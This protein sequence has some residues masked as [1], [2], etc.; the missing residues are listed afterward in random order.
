MSTEWEMLSNHLIRCPLL[1]LP[2]IFPGF[3][4]FS[5]HLTLCIKW[6]KCWSF[7]FSISPSSE[8]SRLIS[9]RINWFDLLAVQGTL[10]S[11]LHHHNSKASILQ[12]PAF[13]MIQI[14]HLYRTTGKTI[15]LATQTFVS[16]MMF[17]LLNMLSRFVIA[18][19]PRRKCL[20]VSRLQSPSTVI[21]EKGLDRGKVTSS[22]LHFHVLSGVYGESL[23][24]FTLMVFLPNTCWAG[25]RVC[26][27]ILSLVEPRDHLKCY[28]MS[29]QNTA[30]VARAFV[31]QK[32]GK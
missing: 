30:C 1:L 32:S 16:K 29:L 6:P 13:F 4:V 2:S 3:R 22:W 7:S 15:A 5:N 9:F 12:C 19:L 28:G 11:L 31:K 8:Y 17:L 20:L 18:F 26:Q 14:S 25:H 10:K 27:P 23:Y 21:L 24:G